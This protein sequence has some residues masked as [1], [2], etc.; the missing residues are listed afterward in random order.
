MGVWGSGEL[1][2][3]ELVLVAEGGGKD[4]EHGGAWEGCGGKDTKNGRLGIGHSARRAKTWNS[5]TSWEPDG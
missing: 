3:G 4:M 5:E 1:D 2:K